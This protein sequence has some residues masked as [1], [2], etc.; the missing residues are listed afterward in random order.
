M[1]EGC[2][3]E[4]DL[5]KQTLTIYGKTERLSVLANRLQAIK[6]IVFN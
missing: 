1:E 5:N 2:L 6:I 3:M 4:F